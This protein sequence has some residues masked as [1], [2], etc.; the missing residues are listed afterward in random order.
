MLIDIILTWVANSL[1]NKQM[2]FELFNLRSDSISDS[3]RS[4][5]ISKQ[6]TEIIG[7]P[8]HLIHLPTNQRLVLDMIDQ[9]ELTLVLM[10][11]E[12]S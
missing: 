2:N 8:E 6:L 5:S 9:S 12:S 11:P 7:V 1:Q 10:A 3:S 4:R